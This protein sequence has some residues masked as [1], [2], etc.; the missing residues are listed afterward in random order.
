MVN[1]SF[2]SKTD[3]KKIT[4]GAKIVR[5]KKNS[6]I[7]HK[8]DIGNIFFI[9]KKGK[10]RIITSHSG[11]VKIFANIGENE[12]FGEVALLGVKYRTASAI[13][14]SDVE[15]YLIPAKRF[16]DYLNKSK[17]F[18]LA[19]LKNLAHRLKK[20]DEEIERITFYNLFARVL[21]LIHSKY[22]ESRSD[23]LNIT[24]QEIAQYL[25]SSRVPVNRAITMLKRTGVIKDTTKGTIKIDHIKLQEILK[26]KEIF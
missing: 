16:K 5:F 9:V 17:K 24:Q 6:T 7:F 10:V 21:L 18:C 12:F 19:L 13:A 23:S 11:K 3:I 2:L 14:L 22:N 26:R 20:A 25:G 4:K 1:H 8:G 15:L